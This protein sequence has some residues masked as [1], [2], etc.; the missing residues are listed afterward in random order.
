VDFHPFLGMLDER[1]ERVVAD[2][3]G[4]QPRSFEE[5]I[6]DYVAWTGEMLA[7]SGYLEGVTGFRNPHPGHE[8]NWSLGEIVSA[9]LEAGLRL[10]TLR[11][12]PYANGFP[13]FEGTEHIGGGRFAPAAGRPRIP[14]MYALSARRET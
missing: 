4:E 1:G 3:G 13:A 2:Y 6:G 5:G 11:E 10:E 14:L 7:P 9:L 8:W 12:Y